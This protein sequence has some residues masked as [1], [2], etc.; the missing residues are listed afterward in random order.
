MLLPSDT[1]AELHFDG[2][3]CIFR[4]GRLFVILQN[5][6]C[7]RIM[8]ISSNRR[9]YLAPESEVLVIEEERNFL[10]SFSDSKS[11]RFGEE[12]VDEDERYVL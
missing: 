10:D 1:Q 9:A 11:F 7:I 2:A 3:L 12:K 5:Y 4:F 8:F 6:K